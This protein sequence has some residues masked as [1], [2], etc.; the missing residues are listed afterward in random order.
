MSFQEFLDYTKQIAEVICSWDEVIQ[1]AYYPTSDALIAAAVF[2]KTFYDLNMPCVLYLIQDKLDVSF[3][4]RED[5]PRLIIGSDYSDLTDLSV[6][7]SIIALIKPTSDKTDGET[8]SNENKILLVNSGDYGYLNEETSLAAVAYFICHS[9]AK[10]LDYIVQFPLIASHANYMMRE[11]SGLHDYIAQDALLG[12]IIQIQ[13][14]MSFLGSEIF[15]ISDALLYSHLPFLPG[16]TGNE[17]V[18]MQ[19]L[20]K[21]GVEVETKNSM[22]KLANLEK[23]EI[24]DL[25]SN[26]ILHLAQHKGHQE[27][28][29]VFIK[30][31]T[32]FKTEPKNSIVSNAWDFAVSINDSVN[33]NRFSIALAVL[34]GNRSDK[35]LQLQRLYIEERKAVPLSFQFLLDHREEV[36]ELSAL[37]YFM[38]DRKINWFNTSVTAGMGLSNG[39]VTSDFPFSVIA[40]GPK[41]LYTIGIRAS[42][43]H[44]IG[45]GL[46]NLVRKILD[47]RNI[48]VEISGTR[49]DVQI[50]VPQDEVEGILLDLNSKL[51]EMIE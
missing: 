15:S 9:F 51:K 17:R 19:L 50:S 23:D 16:L 4:G 20:T 30:E 33:L 45:D 10:T 37:R 31:K 18:V 5:G 25:N 7:S 27:E 22:R 11:Y 14:V 34:L 24:T 43:S 48:E 41:S 12:N 42:K 13:K 44:T 49:L 29:L 39:L 35:L 36:V 21:S 46:L 38:A 26:I 2:G 3:E 6:N 1:I 8:S 47:E 32:D 28:Q 40:P